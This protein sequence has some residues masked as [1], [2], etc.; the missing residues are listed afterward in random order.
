M[1]G[2][3]ER[4][5][6]CNNK[7]HGQRCP[8]PEQSLDKHAQRSSPSRL[9]SDAQYLGSRLV[10][11]VLM[12]IFVCLPGSQCLYLSSICLSVCQSVSFPIYPSRILPCNSVSIQST[13]LSLSL[14]PERQTAALETVSSPQALRSETSS[15]SIISD[16]YCNSFHCY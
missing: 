9:L 7:A 14:L 13:S 8:R 16:V 15:L 3:D 11:T 4:H 10:K 1:R 5:S 6:L 2:R 12:G